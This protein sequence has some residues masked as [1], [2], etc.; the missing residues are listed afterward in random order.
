MTGGMIAGSI[1]A[2]VAVL[3]SLPLR[4]PDDILLNSATVAIGSLIVGT[5]S[6]TLW[7]LLVKSG[8]RP[9]TFALVWGL[10][11]VFAAVF[12]VFGET[13][14]DHFL[15]FVLPL[16]AIVF[17]L[18]GLLTAALAGIQ[19]TS[20]WWMALVAV[21]IALAVGVPLAGRGDEES[22]RLELPPRSGISPPS[23]IGD[24]ASIVILRRLNFLEGE[25]LLR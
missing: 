3:V 16:A 17:P 22:G 10:A 20:S 25:G 2:I 4:S 5:A 24:P 9:A 14:L 7:R 12:A 19:P 6:G 13:Q 11:F 15:G 23:Q 18:T 8:N 21:A 1:A